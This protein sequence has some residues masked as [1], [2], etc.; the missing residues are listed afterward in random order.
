MHS[1]EKGLALDA[2]A[3]CNWLG[4]ASYG[5]RK[6]VFLESR[7]TK[8]IFN[9]YLYF[10]IFSKKNMYFILGGIR[11][12]PQFRAVQESELI[13]ELKRPSNMPRKEL[14]KLSLRPIL[15]NF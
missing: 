9:K 1:W 11:G 14:N 7:V 10:N 13:V 4:E 15:V 2:K 3:A 5:H 8:A 12:I 6:H